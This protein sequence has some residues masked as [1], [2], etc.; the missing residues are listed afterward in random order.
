LISIPHS[1]ISAFKSVLRRAGIRT[2]GTIREPVIRF[3]ANSS[4][5]RLRSFTSEVGVE[6]R[7]EGNDVHKSFQIPLSALAD[8]DGHGSSPVILEPTRD[9][10]ANLRW[11]TGAIPQER[12][13]ALEPIDAKNPLPEPPDEFTTNPPGLR[14]ALHD[15]M[16]CT[17]R[18]SSRYALG[19]IQLRGQAGRI[20]AT[21]GQQM[22][23]QNGYEFPWQEDCLISASRIFDS[24]EFPKD[25]P[26]GVGKTGDWI[27]FSIGPWRVYLH[28][29]EGRFPPA[30]SIL[31]TRNSAAAIVE[32]AP[33]DQAFLSKSLELLPVAPD[34]PHRPV[35]VDLNGQVA[36]RGQRDTAAPPTELILSNSRYSGS[37][38]Q[39]NTNRKYLARAL[40]LGFSEIC[41]SGR[42]GPVFCDDG[43]RQYLWMSLNPDGIIPAS[44]TATRVE[45]GT[46]AAAGPVR[47]HPTTKPRFKMS[48]TPRHEKPTE[49]S[50]SGDSVKREPHPSADPIA[51]GLALAQAVAVRDSLRDALVKTRE[52]IR[53]IKREKKHSQIVASTLASLKQLQS[54][55]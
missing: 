34:D 21:D 49:P 8:C 19:C 43:Q 16:L 42:D 23:V 46:A 31:K 27:V 39:V 54:V 17:D 15:A 40:K 41:L 10:Q 7:Q 2:S 50:R 36:L 3:D 9:G 18:E 55:A 44:Q 13:V 5:L 32:L 28:T 6:L 1:T 20:A 12:S 35:T 29:V 33:T 22:L 24:A 53:A 26:V 11:Q 37:P 51:S 25:Q 4:G 45:S 48:T 14:R 47:L 52:L 30:E 38:L